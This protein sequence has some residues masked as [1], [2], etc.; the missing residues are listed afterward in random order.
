MPAGSF[1]KPAGSKLPFETGC[2]LQVQAEGE[3]IAVNAHQECAMFEAS[4]TVHRMDRSA[5]DARRRGNGTMVD[6]P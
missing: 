4:T 1:R 6:F 2:A 3:A 5:V